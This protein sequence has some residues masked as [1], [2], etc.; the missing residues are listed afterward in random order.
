[1]DGEGIAPGCVARQGAYEIGS[2]SPERG[3]VNFTQLSNMDLWFFIHFVEGNS[4]FRV[5][6][7]QVMEE[8]SSTTIVTRE[9]KRKV[10]IEQMDAMTLFLRLTQNSTVI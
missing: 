5:I 8:V 10:E 2:A 9:Q 1:M 6:M 7:V 3:C 4:M